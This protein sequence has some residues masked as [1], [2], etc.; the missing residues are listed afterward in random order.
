MNRRY[1]K[2]LEATNE[3]RAAYTAQQTEYEA[4]LEES[5]LALERSAAQQA[6]FE[7]QLAESRQSAPRHNDLLDAGERAQV[8]QDAQLDA[9]D[10]LIDRST[11]LADKV[12]RLVDGDRREQGRD[13]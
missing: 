3:L 8:R 7:A 1:R 13:G 9:L 12:E 11:A 4:Q 5:R 10:A 2:Q 6:E